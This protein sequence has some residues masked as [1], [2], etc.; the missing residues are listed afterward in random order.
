MSEILLPVAIAT[1]IS[2]LFDFVLTGCHLLHAICS[3]FTVLLP[4]ISKHGARFL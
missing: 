3:E 4:S 1:S 2:S